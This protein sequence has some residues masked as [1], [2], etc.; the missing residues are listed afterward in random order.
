V[1]VEVN[2]CSFVVFPK[3]RVTDDKILLSVLYVFTYPTV[4]GK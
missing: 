1:V 2:A 3:L 4:E